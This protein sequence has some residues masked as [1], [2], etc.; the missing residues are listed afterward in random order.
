[1]RERLQRGA[2]LES[3]V[4][5]GEIVDA[6]EVVGVERDAELGQGAKL[7]RIVGIIGG[8]HSGGCGGCL[9]EGSALIED[10]DPGSA[11]MEFEGER[12]ADDAAAG[13]A[14]IRTCGRGMHRTSLVGFGRGYSL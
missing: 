11:M 4:E 14:D 3:D 12:E 7:R 8:E 1:M 9:G 5:A 6:G 2:G 13:D 10:G